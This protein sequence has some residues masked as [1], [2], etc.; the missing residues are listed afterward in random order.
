MKR[1]SGLLLLAGMLAC[2]QT[3][4]M[5]T[6]LGSAQDLA[7]IQD[8]SATPDLA[9]NIPKL[10]LSLIA[11]ALGG[12][13]NVDGTGPAARFNL[14]RGS[15]MD[16]AGNLYVADTGNNTIR[17]IVAA[18]GVV[19][20]L[21]GTAGL[22]GSA[23]GIGAAARFYQPNAVA[24]DSSGNLYV[25]DTGNYEI[26]KVVIATGVVTT[27]AGMSAMPGS[28][29]GTGP[30]ARFNA[31]FGVA[32][33]GM[34]NL[35]IAD[36]YNYTIRKVVVATGVVTTLV[37]S[38]GI[39][40]STDGTGAAARFA[41]PE[42]LAMDSAG[43]LYVAEPT[44]HTIRKVVVATGVVTTLA[45]TPGT[46]GSADGTGA[47]AFFNDL[48]ALAVD[49]GGNLYVADTGNYTIR[50]VVV[51]TRAVTTLAGTPGMYGSANGTGSAALFSNPSGVAVDGA[52]NLYVA[53]GGNHILR[54]LVVATRAVTTLAG[55]PAMYGSADGTG[56][57]A[58][59]NNPGGVTADGAGNLYVTDSYSETIRKVVMATGAVTTLA[60][61]ADTY[62]SADG[63][64]PTARFNNPLGV[65][66]DGAGNLYVVDKSSSTI[67]K[68]VIAT[69]AVTTLA[70]TAGMIGVQDGTGPTARFY[71]PGGMAMDGAGNLYVADT[72]G[73]TIRK[74]VV[75]TG[76]V[77]TPVGSPGSGSADGTG[78]A[79]HFNRPSGVAVDGAGNLYVADTG[80][81]TIRKVV[82]ATGTVTT[83][84]GTAGVI[85]STDGTG[86]AARFHSPS[87]VALDGAG[88]LYVADTGNSTVRRIQISS[89]SVATVVGVAG[90]GEVKLGPPP[91]GLSQPVAVA[92][93]PGG[94]LI[95]LDENSVLSAQ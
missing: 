68:V 57:A 33:D 39:S 49:G 23:D 31:P 92:V 94:G 63:T 36:S 95:I 16:G 87:A 84:A 72:N 24:V 18:T 1:K 38:T 85:G 28:A 44:N 55:T 67:R 14:P 56:L 46:S 93:L 73:D 81:H 75:A 80:N 83:L 20:T 78:P 26:R 82:V 47:A 51:A 32:T 88:N 9:M 40:G 3:D 70:G 52:G 65:T 6:D 12:A 34:G 69:G 53:D 35:Y 50:K 4:L 45:G 41:D 60:G 90:Q 17:K 71:Y 54:K 62:G 64:G 2:S 5:S 25:A 10:G 61:S 58:R 21:A 59:F 77:T 91:A 86:S 19:T 13:G 43:N 76:V 29:N 30:A 42:A 48:K 79:A 74:V 11:G 22:S 89:G 15:A 37:G 66:M 8:L 27:L 7:G